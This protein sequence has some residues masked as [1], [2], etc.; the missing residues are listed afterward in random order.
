MDIF[1]RI[2]QI[3]TPSNVKPQTPVT[4]NAQKGLQTVSQ[5]RSSLNLP[6]KPTPSAIPQFDISKYSTA[7]PKPTALDTSRFQPRVPVISQ[8][9][10]QM[11]R[12]PQVKPQEVM[13]V[14]PPEP[15]AIPFQTFTPRVPEAE[16]AFGKFIVGK[17]V[18]PL[19]EGFRRIETA[20]KNTD[21]KGGLE[22]TLDGV[23]GVGLIASI[24]NEV[25][26]QPIWDSIK[27][28][29]K[30]IR[31][32]EITQ[33]DIDKFLF[34]SGGEKGTIF[35]A[36][37]T[38]E[39]EFGK[40]Y[41]QVALG[42][43]R[44]ADFAPELISIP[45]SQANKVG[46]VQTLAREVK[47]TGKGAEEIASKAS[48]AKKVEDAIKAFE[49]K[50]GQTLDNATKTEIK[51][52]VNNPTSFLQML[53][54]GANKLQT[55][56][57][58][59]K[60]GLTT[61]V[62]NIKASIA[63][64]IPT[65]GTSNLTSLGQKVVSN[66]QKER[67]FAKTTVAK[68]ERTAPE[69]K[70]ILDEASD[71]YSPLNNKSAFADAERFV[72]SNSTQDVLNRIRSSQDTRDVTYLGQALMNKFQK[73]GDYAGESQLALEIS[74][75]ATEFGQAIQALSIWKKLSPTGAK[76]WAQKEITR[77]N[78]ALGL[79]EG[80]KGFIKLT[81]QDLKE[82]GE[83]ASK[84]GKA[85]SEYDK[86]VQTALLANLIGSKVP[87]EL[88]SK[89][90]TIQTIAQLL[91]PKTL[92]RNV[93][94][95]MI[96]STLEAVSNAVA[97]PLDLAVAL[98][99]KKRGVANLNPVGF[100]KGFADGFKKGVKES[101]LGI[102][103]LNSSALNSSVQ[104]G[105]IFQSK[106][107]QGLEKALNLALKPFDRAFYEAN[108]RATL[109]GLYKLEKQTKIKELEKRIKNL[110]NQK[111]AEEKLRIGIEKINNSKPSQEIIEQA[112][113]M[114]LYRT[115]QDENVA[116][117]AF[118][119]IKKGLN[120]G[121]D[122]KAK[123]I[124]FRP[125]GLGDFIIK[126]AKVPANL[127]MRASAYSPL[128][129]VKA[130]MEL[131]QPLFKKEFNQAEFV[132]AIARATVG[133]YGLINTGYV[134]GSLGIITPKPDS[135]KDVRNAQ[136]LDGVR[137]YAFNLSALKRYV[138]SGFDPESAKKME[139]DELYSYDWAQPASI[140]LAMG[141]NW[142]ETEKLKKNSAQERLFASFGAGGVAFAD[143]MNTLT[144]QP[145]L[146]GLKTTFSP[147]GL[148][149]G[150]ID[151]VKGAPASF[152]PTVLNQI[153]QLTDNTKRETFDP[154]ILEESKN[155]AIAK[156]PFLSQS[157]PP[158]YDILGKP[159][160][161]YQGGTNTFVN[162][163]LNPAF[164]SKIG[165]DESLKEVIRLY[166][167]TDE[168]SVI[169][170]SVDKKVKIN[171]EDVMLTGQEMSNYQKE[172]GTKSDEYIRKLLSNEDYYKLPDDAKASL[173]AKGLSNINSA[174]KI[175]MFGDK[176]D[177]ISFDV[178]LL[179]NN[180]MDNYVYKNV[181]DA[182]LDQPKKDMQVKID[183]LEILLK[184]QRN[185]QEIS[186]FIIDNKIPA[187]SITGLVTKIKRDE[188]YKQLSPELQK[189]NG[190]TNSQL[191]ELMK[192][193]PQL[194]SEIIQYQQ[195]SKTYDNVANAQY[196]PYKALGVRKGKGGRLKVKKPK[197][198]RSPFASLKLKKPKGLSLKPKKS[199][200][201]AGLKIKPLRVKKKTTK[202]A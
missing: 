174:T 73:V 69:V 172:I 164:V 151:T 91:N 29:V 60:G 200:L 70:K 32:G 143:A 21:N 51:K 9:Q 169:P 130:V 147:Q 11:S 47:L 108:Y 182:I 27:L 131:A 61:T 65:S 94:G 31:T 89:I 81:D 86:S 83:Q 79:K 156:V 175:N 187:S 64:G 103:T 68:A 178:S 122:R 18:L 14:K 193:K 166:E 129:Y 62:E 179:Q 67:R 2:R 87:K 189:Y 59:A 127:L 46:K 123:K 54:Q 33:N 90:A 95:N 39:D 117:S 177:S 194:S 121:Y 52:T 104:N 4:S 153:N 71:L 195:F 198:P 78:N 48:K 76:L 116:T 45:G 201:T 36:F 25:F 84:I 168:T 111:G 176:P 134:L 202:L 180:Q 159:A 97:T 126:Y 183:Q 133:S 35:E 171:G 149:Q 3:I 41:G 161:R 88:G 110:K 63:K 197:K 28:G 6:P 150:V 26:I 96:F 93:A 107:M 55:G 152:V 74:Q 158:R 58:E 38:N 145:V 53:R 163:M 12:L 114:G 49:T 10:P 24:P 80:A 192:L 101:L 146:Q 50:I 75:R 188:V 112:H 19:N 128:G 106:I 142:A 132:N 119:F 23:S 170:N 115:F 136:Q 1:E 15:K 34:T 167:S 118:S 99:T 124:I 190:L 42:V 125:F 160:E 44:F 43:A 186:K 20:W 37:G 105:F 17:G 191:D 85:T 155:I 138:A 181:T 16:T 141:A 113:Y 5:I 148:V 13:S 98:F 184:G 154:N 120:I 7:F 157:L 8:P 40:N 82:I 72:N 162:V 140:P 56:V 139:G 77:A 66:A 92:I 173:L 137:S 102:D 22:R 135:S 185:P 57:T 144:D 109:E 199:N 30:G 165:S 100:G 196:A